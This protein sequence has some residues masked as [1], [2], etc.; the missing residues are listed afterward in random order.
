MRSMFEVSF[1]NFLIRVFFTCAQLFPPAL[2][3]YG[4]LWSRKQTNRSYVKLIYFSSRLFDT[5]MVD[6]LSIFEVSFG[7]FLMRGCCLCLVFLATFVW[8]LGLL[9]MK[10]KP[11]GII[12]N[13][14]TSL[15]EALTRSWSMWSIVKFPLSSFFIRE[16]G[17]YLCPVFSGNAVWLRSFFGHEIQTTRR[18]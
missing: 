6:V 8:F 4:I 13:F 14:Y 11:V 1:R 17:F 12:L 9:V 15:R 3:G 5:F 7:S 10:F 16:V 2:F 18:F